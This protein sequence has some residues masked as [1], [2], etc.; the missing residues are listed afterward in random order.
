MHLLYIYWG[1]ILLHVLI[2]LLKWGSIEQ[3]LGIVQ[4]DFTL[5]DHPRNPG[6]GIRV[7]FCHLS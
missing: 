2:F 5:R 3:S 7:G 1:I 6:G 4:W